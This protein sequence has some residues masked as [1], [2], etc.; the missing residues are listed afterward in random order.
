MRNF[1]LKNK[2]VLEISLV[3]PNDAEAILNYTKIIGGES[4]FITFGPE[5]VPYT[6]EEEKKMLSKYHEHSLYPMFV[7]RIEGEVVTL[8]DLGGIDRDR[9]RHNAEIGISVLRKYWNQ[10]V[11]KAMMQVLIEHA[12]ATK[13]IQNIYLKVRSDNQNAIHLYESFGFKVVGTYPRQMKI[14]NEYFDTLLMALLL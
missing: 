3:T 8:A 1:I 10:G 7:G 11:G 9:L 14:K 12:K 13:I 2:K 5:G 4:D 6:I